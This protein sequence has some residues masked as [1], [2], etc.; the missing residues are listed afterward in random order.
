MG[1]ISEKLTYLNTTKQKLKDSINALGGDITSETTFRNYVTELDNIYS[2]L[3]KTT[4]E[5]SNLSLS[6]TL[7]GKLNIEAYKGDTEQEGTPT[8]SSSQ[9]INV[10]T[11]QQEVVV[12]NKNFFNSE[13]KIGNLNTNTG[14]EQTGYYYAITSNFVKVIP[15][16][17]ISIQY[18]YNY[19]TSITG[20]IVIY[21]YGKDK[22]FKKF[23]AYSGKSYSIT[24]DS[25]T[26]YIKIRFGGKN[27]HTNTIS[28]Y[29]QMQ[30]EYGT[31]TTYVEHQEQTKTL[32]LGDIELAK[33]GT[34]QDYLYKSGDKWYISNK[35]KKIV[36]DGTQTISLLN[37]DATNTTRVSY[38]GL[39]NGSVG[40]ALYCNMLKQA[41]NWN[42]DKVGISY[43]A[44]N[45]ALWFRINKTTIG[46]TKN[47]V[48]T[49]LT[50]NNLIVYIPLATATDIE[51]TNTTLI[52]EL[53][54]LE[55]MYSYSGQTN[56]SV[57][58]SL[59]MILSVSA[60]KGE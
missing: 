50:S 58:G 42:S 7:K 29:E 32:H 22:S 5:G 21:Q 44:N 19:D 12:S 48:N 24:L 38:N 40:I 16:S 11:G 53:N 56:I 10:V 31:A 6:P 47:E 49:F 15:S 27:D 33:I 13:I 8:P 28:E 9:D 2:S 34:Y 54:E 26:Y 43:D 59:P 30:I 57:T 14:E 39:A 4:G 23:T 25:D 3:P 20:Q 41:N 17:Q 52:E 46:T 35:T 18:A 37:T 36:L 55:K 45:G 51:I 1:T 60:L